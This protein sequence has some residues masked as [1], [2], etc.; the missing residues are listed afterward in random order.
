MAAPAQADIVRELYGRRDS[1]PADKRAV[2]EELYGRMNPG[3]G[4][5]PGV[6]NPLQANPGKYTPTGL[7]ETK[8]NFFTSPTG[9]L[10]TGAN[11]ITGGFEAMAQ[12]ERADKYRGAAQIVTG[13]GKML[14]PVAI[15]ATIP[16]AITAPLA[17]AATLV[18]GA[19]GAGAGS[20]IGKNVTKLA[21]GSPEAQDLGETVGGVA[22][23]ATGGPSD[24]TLGTAKEFLTSKRWQAAKERYQ[25]KN[26]PSAP[27][28]PLSTP[29]PTA[30]PAANPNAPPE[31]VPQ[32]WWDRL[33]DDHKQLL[34]D[35]I[36]N[37]KT[38]AVAPPGTT[39]PK[40]PAPTA[41]EPNPKPE[42]TVAP[43]QPSPN[44]T[45]KPPVTAN[46]PEAY[47]KKAL[48]QIVSKAEKTELGKHQNEFHVGDVSEHK[49]LNVA[50]Y[51]NGEGV[52]ADAYQKILDTAKQ[53]G[54]WSPID[55]INTEAFKTGKA[56]G[57]NGYLPQ[58]GYTAVSD[59][60]RVQRGS[61]QGTTTPQRII[62]HL[63]EFDKLRK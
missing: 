46:T 40:T 6:P 21:G 31:G 8:P 48:D 33:S 20:M 10:R 52:S 13:A 43:A 47:T 57:Y 45:L 63:K 53:T 61:Y 62:E 3:G 38:Q 41:T 11:D 23:A 50:R 59:A 15:G 35:K 49:A 26:A 16:S 9:L 54:D 22:G 32:A 58:N 51:L 27:A 34:R 55:R 36:A 17:T 14:T 19:V 60:R 24:E 5:G 56:G 1:L 39:A 42:A 12:P 30:S 4:E 44:G 7:Q 37:G 2:V 25:A 18:R 29:T 28:G